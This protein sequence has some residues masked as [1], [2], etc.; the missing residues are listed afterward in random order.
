MD[1]EKLKKTIETYHG[2][3]EV[4]A[5]VD[6]FILEF[7][8]VIE[9]KMNDA[10][11][12]LQSRIENMLKVRGESDQVGSKVKSAL[13]ASVAVKSDENLKELQEFLQK[14]NLLDEKI[15]GLFGV[16]HYNVLLQRR[17]EGFRRI[18]EELFKLHR[19]E[20]QEEESHIQKLLEYG[21]KLQH[22]WACC[23]PLLHSGDDIEI[24][25]KVIKDPPPSPKKKAS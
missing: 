14:E 6:A 13:E 22:I 20:G 15:R 10:N 12:D 17:L 16:I 23:E 8:K 3:L 21:P 11:L 9:Q 19:G 25:Q 4:W 5:K 24:F 1:Q 7:L 18:F 2:M